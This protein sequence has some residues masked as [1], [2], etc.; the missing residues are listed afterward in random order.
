[1][2]LY[3]E[4]AKTCSPACRKRVSRKPA[5]PKEMTSRARWMRREK[6]KRPVTLD[7]KPASS[8]N[9]ETWCSFKA[10]EASKVGAGLGFVLGDG[11]G[12]IDLDHCFIDGEL[13]D[14]ARLIVD[15]CPPT[16]MEVSQSGDGLHIFGLLPEGPGR[17]IRRDGT[18]VEFYSVGRYIAVTGNRFDKAPSI[19]ADLSEVV[20][21]VL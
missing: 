8:T 16:F 14:W 13:A 18:N 10:A 21:S 19:L 11:I 7:R 9:P 12:C 3:R 6:S 1:M 15:R 2:A 5:L 4:D 17:N 20:S